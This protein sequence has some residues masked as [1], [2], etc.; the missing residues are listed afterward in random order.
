MRSIRTRYSYSAPLYIDMKK[1][2]MIQDG[3]EPDPETG[4]MSWVEEKDEG[5]DSGEDEKVY[6]GK[7]GL[8]LMAMTEQLEW[9]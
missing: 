9:S 2:V 1:R 8:S 6:I 4:E 7:V 3:D 5:G